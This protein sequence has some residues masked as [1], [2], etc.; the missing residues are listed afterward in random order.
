VKSGSG[1]A[2]LNTGPGFRCAQS[3]LLARVLHGLP[4][5]DGAKVPARKIV[6]L[7]YPGNRE[8]WRPCASA[9]VAR[10]ERSEIRER[11]ATLSA[12]PGLRGACLRAGHFRPAPVAQSGLLAIS[13]RSRLGAHYAISRAAA[14][15]S[16]LT[17]TQ[18][19]RAAPQFLHDKTVSLVGASGRSSR[20]PHFPHLKLRS[21]VVLLAEV[22]VPLERLLRIAGHA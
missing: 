11:S 17:S 4:P 22:E 8:A 5:P 12:G 6:S 1:S 19:P 15:M 3:G 16:C 20:P 21:K 13:S 7:E 14:F 10:T 18:V 2:S 9:F